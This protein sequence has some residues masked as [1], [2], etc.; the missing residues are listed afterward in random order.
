MTG[1]GV[2]SRGSHITSPPLAPMGLAEFLRDA[3]ALLT[4]M[5]S[6]SLDV[7][8]QLAHSLNHSASDAGATELAE[9]ARALRRIASGRQPVTLVGAMHNLSAALARAQREYHLAP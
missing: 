2:H 1:S 9:A 3:D 6:E 8:A 4:L 7:V 5:G